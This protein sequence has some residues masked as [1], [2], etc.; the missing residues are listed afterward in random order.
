[1]WS[2][3][4][5]KTKQ[6]I[7]PSQYNPQPIF[8]TQVMSEL[9]LAFILQM[10]KSPPKGVQICSRQRVYQKISLLVFAGEEFLIN[11]FSR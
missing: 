5:K 1:M 9:F 2:E 10:G 7:T 6:R 11:S 3:E 4:K 8:Q